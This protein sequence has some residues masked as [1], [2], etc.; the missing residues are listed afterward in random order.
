MPGV[1]MVSVFLSCTGEVNVDSVLS[2]SC[3]SCLAV[4]VRA[5]FSVTDNAAVVGLSF[6]FIPVSKIL[7][8]SEVFESGSHM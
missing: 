1:S 2:G 3:G 5:S 8:A 4:F 6:L 7:G